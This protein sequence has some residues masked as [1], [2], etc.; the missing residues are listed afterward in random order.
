MFKNKN[1]TIKWQASA[2]LAV[3]MFGIAFLAGQDSSH[4]F[5]SIV[6]SPSSAVFDGTTL[7]VLKVPKW[8]ALTSNERNL[9][10]DSLPKSKL[11]AIPK[12]DAS[13]LKMGVS[14]L[15]WNNSSDLNIRNA[16]ITF[17]VP[18]MGNYK[19]DGVEGAGSHLAVD[20]KI[21]VGTPVYSIGNGVVS[22]VSSQSSGFGKHIVVKHSNF[23]SLNDPNKKET[24]FSSYCHLSEL[25]VSKGDVVVKGQLIGKSGQSGLSTTPHLHF[26]LDNDSAPWHPY[27]PFT[28]KEASDAGYSFFEAIN[29]GFHKDKAL[30]TTVN[31][32]MYAQKYIDYNGETNQSSNDEDSSKDE[33][34]ENKPVDYSTVKDKTIVDEKT[35]VE[36]DVSSKPVIVEKDKENEND[37]KVVVDKVVDKTSSVAKSSKSEVKSI[38]KSKFF[39]D[40]S[41][42]HSNYKAIKFLKDNNIVG[43][44]PDNSFRPTNTV[45]RVE[46]LKFILKG[47]NANL[48][49]ANV[50]PFSD[51]D[52]H[53][54]YSQ[55][56]ATGYN[57]HIIDG[58]PD[59]S[60]KPA[61]EVNKAE[62]LKMLF[63]AM[64]VK[65]PTVTEDVYKDVSVNDW[66]A[67][68][69]LYAKNHNLLVISNSMFH[70]EVGIT[71]AEVAEIMYRTILV[72]LSGAPKYS[73]GINIA[74]GVLKAYFG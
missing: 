45:T 44:Y 20:I 71:R 4:Y 48:I 24:L 35:V 37:K 67:S 63:V 15:G 36:I 54:W 39:K 23:P 13:V 50:L 27:W 61:N 73:S 18:Y 8:T 34:V 52:T 29:A 25:F 9:N 43:G 38:I 33:G 21:P 64:D 72:K 51:T 41:I 16:K 60:F 7:P 56:V 65:L 55:Y 28:S 14:G 53:S 17:S 11:I 74:K 19:L 57:K 68:Y 30:K 22:K 46:A 47:V 1:N 2:L 62:F 10:Y 3:F 12:Y 6:H 66:F 69:V 58:Y 5:T 40:V 59:K 42:S 32:M 70:P 49:S 31:P 26:Q